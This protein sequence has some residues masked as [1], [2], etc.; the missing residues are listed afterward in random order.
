[1]PVYSHSRLDTYKKCPLKYK[2]Q[3]V[4]HLRR[5]E[6]SIEAFLG[7]RVHEA[8]EKLY[9]DLLHG[10]RDTK[11]ELLVY[12]EEQWEKNWNANTVKIVRKEYSPNH[13]KSAGLECI[14]RYYDR[15]APFDNDT[16]VAVERRLDF[17][18]DPENQY[19]ITGLID[20]LVKTDDGIWEIHDYKTSGRLPSQKEVNE[21]PQLGL[22]QIGLQQTWPE[23]QKVR[24]IWHFLRFDT[25]LSSIQRR[26]HLESL[27][28]ETM[29]LI[30][31]IEATESFLPRESS[32]C[33][34][35]DFQ[36]LCP[37]K[38]HLFKIGAL[39]AEQFRAEAGVQLVDRY[40]HLRDQEREIKALLEEVRKQLIAYARRER[41]DIVSGTEQLASIILKKR[42]KFPE[43]G[44]ERREALEEMLHQVGKWDEVSSL[45]LNRLDR[46][47]R[48]KEWNFELEEKIK[49]FATEQEEVR[50]NLKKKKEDK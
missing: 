13:Y 41:V 6:R 12:F 49:P 45:N 3:Y 38:K 37:K 11:T 47:L 18:L 42:S 2:F 48:D 28:A 40:A 36:D 16:T 8:L 21:D 34:W 46:I 4:D 43:S 26:D 20:R 22:Y 5:E 39:P 9:E 17:S 29:N 10:K 14:Q 33:D 50:V 15:H 27:R 30:D 32:L 1:M 7:S 35:C 23:V 25:L 24:L 19:R 44:D 31:E